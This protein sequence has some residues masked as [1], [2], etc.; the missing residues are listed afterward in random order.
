MSSQSTISTRKVDPS[1][2]SSQMNPPTSVVRGW[3]IVA[4]GAGAGAETDGCSCNDARNE[5]SSVIPSSKCTHV[6]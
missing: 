4:A 3:L 2:T 6:L 1:E 5:Y